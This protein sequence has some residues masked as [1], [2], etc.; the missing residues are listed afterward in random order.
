MATPWPASLCHLRPVA[1]DM[2]LR[3]RFSADGFAPVGKRGLGKPPTLG[4]IGGVP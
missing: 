1:G 4:L 2:A 3:D